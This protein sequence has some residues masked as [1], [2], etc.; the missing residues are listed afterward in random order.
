MDQ[1][2]GQLLGARQIVRGD[3]LDGHAASRGSRPLRIGSASDRVSQHE[4]TNPAEPVDA[5]A[6]G[7]SVW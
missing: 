7:S 1:Q 5:D 2:I 6:E 4:T 3:D